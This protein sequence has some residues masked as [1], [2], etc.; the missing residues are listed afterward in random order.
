MARTNY[1]F[2]KRQREM[3]KKQKKEEKLRLKKAQSEQPTE[4]EVN[5]TDAAPSPAVP[6]DDSTPA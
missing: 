5:T 1:G 4:G 2:E 6:P 3:A